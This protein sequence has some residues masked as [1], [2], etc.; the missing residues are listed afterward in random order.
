MEFD[1]IFLGKAYKARIVTAN[2]R[3]N[4]AIY[5]GIE[6]FDE[7]YQEWESWCDVTTNLNWFSYDENTITIKNERYVEYDK[8]LI[9]Y[10]TEFGIIEKKILEFIPQG[11]NFYDCYLV[12]VTKLK[13]LAVAL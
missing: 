4:G 12:N 7:E 3:S 2:Y 8:S 5:I 13:E 1:F 6:T 10:L 9:Q 11:Y